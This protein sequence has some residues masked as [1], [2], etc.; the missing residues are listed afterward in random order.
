MHSLV[1]L[2]NYAM[3]WSMQDGKALIAQTS[4]LGYQSD[5]DSSP[6]DGNA[7]LG[8]LGWSDR[9]PQNPLHISMTASCPYFSGRKWLLGNSV[10][11][12]RVYSVET[13]FGGSPSHRVQ[14][15]VSLSNI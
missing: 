9:Q 10:T 4:W 12:A 5:T 1:A 11:T 14:Q 7:D 2:T 13:S 6:W 15:S 3:L 8:W